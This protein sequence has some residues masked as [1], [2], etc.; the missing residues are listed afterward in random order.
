LLVTMLGR[1]NRHKRLT[2]AN[3]TTPPTTKDSLIS[4]PAA[5]LSQARRPHQPVEARKV[6]TNPQV[7][8]SKT[9]ALSHA[10]LRTLE[11][12]D[13]PSLAHQLVPSLG[14]PCP[15]WPG[16]FLCAPD[17]A[18]RAPDITPDWPCSQGLNSQ[19]KAQSLPPC[20][21]RTT[22]FPGWPARNAVLLRVGRTCPNKRSSARPCTS[23]ESSTGRRV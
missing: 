21:G 23:G 14:K 8:A 7:S 1:D 3:D 10:F 6:P 12:R 15:P 5:A 18:E 2:P 13:L 11:P 4:S 16:L 19:V 20:R 22:R 9:A 17:A